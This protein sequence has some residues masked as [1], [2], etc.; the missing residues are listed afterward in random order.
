MTAAVGAV[1]PALP[2]LQEL[3]LPDPVALVPSA[4][5][6]PGLKR[7]RL[8][9]EQLVIDMGEGYEWDTYDPYDS[10][11][12]SG[13]AVRPGTVVVAGFP[14]RAPYPGCTGCRMT[15]LTSLQVLELS[16]E[17]EH[18]PPSGNLAAAL[19]ALSTLPHVRRVAIKGALNL[20]DDY[21]G[22]VPHAQALL[23]HARP[24]LEMEILDDDQEEE[25]EDSQWD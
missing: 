8:N 9:A 6:L 22:E 18:A 2:Q 24:G 4:W 11:Q 23:L 15:A 10:D 5:Q 7:L 20:D 25:E 17:E 1:L 3:E 21:R 12:P 19:R 16:V 13:G 14:C